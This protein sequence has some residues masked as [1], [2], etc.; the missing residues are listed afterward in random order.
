MRIPLRNGLSIWILKK[1]EPLFLTAF[2]TPSASFFIPAS[3]NI[4]KNNSKSESLE[5]ISAFFCP[6][7]IKKKMAYFSRSF[8][9]LWHSLCFTHS[10]THF[11][12]QEANSITSWKKSFWQCSQRFSLGFRL[13][14]RK[15]IFRSGLW[16]WGQGIFWQR[17]QINYS[18]WHKI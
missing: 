3:M 4:P 17:R 7:A 5:T 14:I 13:A 2:G 11:Q 15:D 6:S 12:S 8:L 16:I 18:H 9:T 10:F 1:T